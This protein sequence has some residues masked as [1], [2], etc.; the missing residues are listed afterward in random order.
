LYGSSGKPVGS[1]LIAQPFTRDEYFQPRPSAASYNASASSSA[2][3]AASNPA[4]R[5]RVAATLG[6]I[7]RYKS[8]PQA[9]RIVAPDIEQWIKNKNLKG[10]A[11]MNFDKWR[12]DNPN[13]SLQDVPG[14]MVTTSASG[15]DPH[16][17][18]ENALFQLDRVAAKW[19]ALTRRDPMQVRAE[20]QHVLDANEFE[21]LNGLVGEKMVNVLKVNLE[22]TKR[23]NK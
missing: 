5:A 10:S 6:P 11:S 15:L 17:T 16:I 19:T 9:G 2:A 8:G 1:A 23:F 3:L 20:I 13:A 18:F 12:Q 14:D 7:V 4:L 22:L 21:P